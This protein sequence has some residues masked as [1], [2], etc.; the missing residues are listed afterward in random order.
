MVA[1]RFWVLWMACMA[2][3][4]SFICIVVRVNGRYFIRETG[5]VHVKRQSLKHQSR[6]NGTRTPDTGS[7]RRCRYGSRHL[8]SAAVVIAG[9]ADLRPDHGA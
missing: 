5:G 1:M 2:F 4:V 7:A 8:S 9:I 6:D 3:N